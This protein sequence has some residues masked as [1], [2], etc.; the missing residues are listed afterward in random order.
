MLLV[1][2]QGNFGGKLTPKFPLFSSFY[3]PGS[4]CVSMAFSASTLREAAP[5]L[6]RFNLYPSEFVW[7]T[8]SA[9]AIFLWNKEIRLRMRLKIL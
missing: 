1:V 2:H 7:S 9:I 6:W 3:P 4:H 5:H 8:T